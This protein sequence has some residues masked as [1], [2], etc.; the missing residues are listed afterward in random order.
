M[1]Y[2]STYLVYGDY[3]I[4]VNNDDDDVDDECMQYVLCPPPKE[5]WETYSNRTVR[6][7]VRQSRFMSGACLL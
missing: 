7:S 2:L 6:Q 1:G 5:L 3:V 4:V